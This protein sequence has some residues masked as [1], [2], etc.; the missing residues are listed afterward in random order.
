MTISRRQFVS[1]IAGAGIA[2]GVHYPRALPD[3]PALHKLWPRAAAQGQTDDPALSARD[4]AA[5]ELSLPIFSG[6]EANELAAVIAATERVTAGNH[7][8]REAHG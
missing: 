4:W 5:R 2:S 3:Q 7:V 1:G 6:M 8:V